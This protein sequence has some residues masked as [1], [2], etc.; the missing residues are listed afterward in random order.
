MDINWVVVGTALL[1]GALV[2][3]TG[4][5]AGAIMT[6]TL[7]GFFGV[8]L[9]VAVATDLIFATVTKLIGVPFHHRQGS[10]NWTLA[11]KLWSGSIPGTVVGVGLVILVATREQ[12]SWLLW[13]L[14]VIVLLTAI[15]LGRRAMTANGPAGQQ[16]DFVP[17]PGWVGPTGGFGIGSAVALTSVGAGALGMALLVRL[18]PGDVKPSEL[19][20][21][22]LVHAIPIALIAG[23]AYG[24]AGLVSWPLLLM[25]L[26]G[27]TPG[28]IFGS[29]LAGKISARV[30]NGGLSLILL[31]V[32]ILVVWRSL[33]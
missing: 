28:V 32:V 17:L 21:T 26:M 23:G 31:T 24:F 1:V 15:T 7:V 2:G 25:M 12:T 9:P 16:T 29:L 5:G 13:P 30:L 18:S 10:I 22:D 8:S 4:V 14:V 11:K 3:V 33:N 27:S 19:V 20:G 6:P